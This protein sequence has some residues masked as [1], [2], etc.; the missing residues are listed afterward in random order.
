M[1]NLELLMSVVASIVLAGGASTRMGM[2]KQL[3]QFGERSLIGHVVEVAIA[4]VCNP[5]IVVL[6]ASSDRIK[7]EVERLDVRVVE[8]PHWAEGMSTSI[9]TGIKTLKALNPEVEAVVLMLCDQPFVSTQIIDRLVAS[10][11]ATGKPIIASEYA[12]ISGVPALFSRAL[13]SELTALSDDVGARQVIKQHAQAVFG[14]PFPEG[15][16][17]LDTPKDYEAFQAQVAP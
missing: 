4:S 5:I 8:N 16:I 14:V 1:L 6:G 9:R 7:P 2:P 17:D 10:Y 11:R 12:E 13:F 15:A 3:L